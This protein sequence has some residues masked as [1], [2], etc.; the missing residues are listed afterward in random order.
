MSGQAGFAKPCVGG[1]HCSSEDVITDANCMQG[2]MGLYSTCHLAFLANSMRLDGDWESHDGR[3]LKQ[4]LSYQIEVNDNKFVKEH[5][6][7]PAKL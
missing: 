2:E 3:I 4:Y 6:T 7:R 1:P 5:Q